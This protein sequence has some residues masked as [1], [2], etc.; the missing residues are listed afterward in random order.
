MLMIMLKLP[1]PIAGQII[2]TTA[3][4]LTADL[5]QPMTTLS[6]AAVNVGRSLTFNPTRPGPPGQ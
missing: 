5:T 6:C 4:A 2:V 3:V 1:V